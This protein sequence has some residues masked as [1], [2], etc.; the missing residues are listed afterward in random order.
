M[1]H[2]PWPGLGQG[3]QNIAAR[4]GRWYNAAMTETPEKDKSAPENEKQ[5]PAEASPGPAGHDKWVKLGFVVL[6]IAA[7]VAVYS[8]QTR[9]LKIAGWG[10]DFTAALDQARADNRMV[11]A[12]FVKKPPSATAREIRTRVGRSANRK[13]IEQG[14]F[15]PVVVTTSADADLAKRYKV[16]TFPTLLVILPDGR[17]RNR[18][19]GNVG[20]VPF[21]QQ[22]L[23]NATE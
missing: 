3:S 15:I 17:E 2:T 13:A 22:F 20:E 1:H 11:V 23:E 7:A 5:S 6:L 12:L 8:M 10:D 4:T 14:N 18:A 21:R 9:E 16:T 19:E